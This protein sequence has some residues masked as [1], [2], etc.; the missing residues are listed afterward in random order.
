MLVVAVVAVPRLFQLHD[1]AALFVFAS[2]FIFVPVD[3]HRH[4]NDNGHSTQ[5]TLNVTSRALP[6]VCSSTPPYVHLLFLLPAKEVKAHFKSLPRRYGLSVEP[7]DALIHMKILKEAAESASTSSQVRVFVHPQSS[8]SVQ[9]ET[10][11]RF[12][13]FAG[14]GGEGGRCR[15]LVVCRYSPFLL[16]AISSALRSV[17]GAM[18]Y[19]TLVFDHDCRFV[20]VCVF[21]VVS[22]DELL[23]WRRGGARFLDEGTFDRKHISPLTV[24]DSRAH[25]Y[26]PRRGRNDDDERDVHDTHR[27]GT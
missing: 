26:L 19:A 12:G 18:V 14:D 22:F 21:A 27:G 7:A 13:G 4:D 11:G 23:V 10:S 20:C 16:G 25:R 2:H 6:L 17:E 9:S 15:V 3:V 8:P 24:C 5:P 1:V